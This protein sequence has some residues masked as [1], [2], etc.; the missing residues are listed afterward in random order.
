L[1]MEEKLFKK[2]KD[3]SLVN[4]SIKSRSSSKKK[5]RSE[6]LLFSLNPP[7]AQGYKFGSASYT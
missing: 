3:E 1:K 6:M 5:D 2:K 7:S 4:E